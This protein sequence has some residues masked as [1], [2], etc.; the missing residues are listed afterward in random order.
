MVATLRSHFPAKFGRY[1]EPFF[2]GGAL[3]FATQPGRSLIADS[4]AELINLYRT[5]R[6]DVS[7]LIDILEKRRNTSEEFYRI[8]A[9]AW[10]SL[11]SVEAAARTIFLNRT[12]YNGLYRVNRSGGF[13]TPFG[14]YA[15]PTIVDHENLRLASQALASATIVHGDYKTVLQEHAAPGDLVFLDPPYLPISKYSDFKRYTKEQFYEEDHIALAEE[16]ERLSDLGCHV[17]LTNSNHPLVHKL[18]GHHR[19]EVHST[20]RNISSKSASRNGEDV[21]VVVEPSRKRR[22]KL[23]REDLSPQVGCYP[24]T[25]Y[26]GSK[27]K[28]LS[29]IWNVASQFKHETVL[30]LFSGSGIVGY[31]F[32][33]QGKR[34]V[35]NDH[36]AS[37]FANARAMIANSSVTVGRD[38][39]EKMLRPVRDADSFVHDTFRDIYFTPAELRTIDAIRSH[40]NSLR[41][42]AKKALLRAA[43]MRACIKR[44]PRGIFTFAGHRYDDG[45]SDLR[46]SI[47]EHFLAAVEV[48]SAAVFSNGKPCAAHRGDALECREDNVDLVYMD[49]PY[50]SRHSDNEYVRRYHFIEGLARDWK[51]VSIQEHTVTKKF[52]SYPTPFSTHQ[53]AIDAFDR[54]FKRYRRSTIIVSYSSNSLPAKEEMIVL[55][56]KHKGRVE[57]V[58][59]NH[60]Y[61]FGNRANSKQPVRNAVEE[62]LFVGY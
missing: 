60:R 34:V 3:F 27:R 11:D 4:N 10:E 44:Q 22:V 62:Y 58:P 25:R 24:S 30:D 23:V 6:D 20:R 42:G 50:F 21:L 15:N 37:A 17:L 32:K 31:M 33:A 26:M 18:Y 39:A 53:G 41:D 38:E 51:G 36:M 12:C 47:G 45:R 55:L 28:L 29:D 2:G 13:N 49:P 14:R 16:V 5:I 54:L 1:I 56:S 52:R 9:Q 57:V 7:G 43:L 59:I 61:S 48:V 19:L 46:Q 35:T 40:I 8:R